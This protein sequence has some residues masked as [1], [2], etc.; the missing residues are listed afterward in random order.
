MPPKP[1][2]ARPRQAGPIPPRDLSRGINLS[3]A[4]DVLRRVEKCLDPPGGCS[5]GLPHPT[6]QREGVPVGMV[7]EHRFAFYYWLT[8]K[9]EKRYDARAKR[10]VADHEFVAPDLVTLDWHNDIGG[11]CDVIES[12]LLR[13]DQRNQAEIGFF[14]WAGLRLI[15]DGHIY[16][17]MWLNAI[18]DVYAI[19]KQ[20]IRGRNDYAVKDRYGREHRVRCFH[21]P[22]LLVD[23]RKRRGH[24]DRPLIWDID[25][26]YFI[27]ANRWWSPPLSDEAIVELLNP[28]QEWV[29][30]ILS[31]LDAVTI[32]LEPEY[33][34]GL[35]A[36]LHLLRQWEKVFLSDPLFSKDADWR[37]NLLRIPARNRL[38]GK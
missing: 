12:E 8:H 29:R 2:D 11:D 26:D 24:S 34:G 1:L 16:P 4:R 35:G 10:W 3:L 37:P 9:E 18:G 36:S 23:A 19:I 15:N 33:T 5:T 14:C 17:A 22:S 28:A 25:L 21:K 7:I 32:A 38:N 6:R 27:K 13:L 30:H 31:N 20:D